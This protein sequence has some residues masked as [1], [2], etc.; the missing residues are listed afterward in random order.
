[1]WGEGANPSWGKMSPRGKSMQ[2]TWEWY[3]KKEITSLIGEGIII[4]ATQTFFRE[5]EVK[6]RV[7]IFPLFCIVLMSIQDMPL[8]G[9]TLKSNAPPSTQVL[10]EERLMIKLCTLFIKNISF[11]PSFLL[12]LSMGNIRS[13]MKAFLQSTTSFALLMIIL[14]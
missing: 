1:M 3:P 13:L 2:N 11:Q 14:D 9:R 12:L 4:P 10:N 8:G 7:S 5:K 6:S